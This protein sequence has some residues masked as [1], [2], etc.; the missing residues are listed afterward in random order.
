MLRRARSLIKRGAP[1]PRLA[2]RQQQWRE[3]SF[4]QDA[5]TLYRG[6][7]DAAVRLGR[8]SGHWQYGSVPLGTRSPGKLPGSP[9]PSRSRAAGKLRSSAALVGLLGSV[10][11]SKEGGG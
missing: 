9:S 2:S 11:R 4:E 6:V 10:Q 8:Y 1:K 5:R 3:L 7:G